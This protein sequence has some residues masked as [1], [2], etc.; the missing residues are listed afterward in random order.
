MQLSAGASHVLALSSHGEVWAWGS[1]DSG[2]LGV[3][4]RKA[5]P[6][7]TQIAT[8]SETVIDRQAKWFW[9][10]AVVAHL[11]YVLLWTLALNPENVSLKPQQF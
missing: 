11:P 5:R 7:P 1:N 10:A 2:Q 8:F 9:I 6:T 4:D 3:G